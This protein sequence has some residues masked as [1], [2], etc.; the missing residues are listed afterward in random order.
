MIALKEKVK[1]K[2]G[3]IVI[4]L[5]DEL[6]D[7]VDFVLILEKQDDEQNIGKAKLARLQKYKGIITDNNF[8]ISESEWYEQ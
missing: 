5:P 4:T 3:K 2:N 1:A 6:K 8:T 7:E